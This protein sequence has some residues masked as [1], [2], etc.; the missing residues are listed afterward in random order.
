MRNLLLTV[1]CFCFILANGQTGKLNPTSTTT[2]WVKNTKIELVYS[3]PDSAGF[4]PE[5]KPGKAIYFEYRRQHAEYADMTDD[6]KVEVIAFQIPET[7]KTSFMLKDKQL[8]NA[9]A[10]YLLGCFCA[11]RGFKP[12][13]KGTIS[14]K[15]INANTWQITFDIQAELKDFIVIKKYKG[16]F[17]LKSN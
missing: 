16:R 15:K 7:T 10:Y 11:D 17:I 5:L 8:V 3:Q 2:K 14:G 4:A 6:E 1:F 12:I 9:N 13:T